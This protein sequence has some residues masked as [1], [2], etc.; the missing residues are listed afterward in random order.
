MQNEKARARKIHRVFLLIDLIF[1]VGLFYTQV[2]IIQKDYSSSTFEETK[3]FLVVLIE[4]LTA[5][6]EG[7]FSLLLVVSACYITSWVTKSTGKR[8]NTCLLI[9]HIINLILLIA[10]TISV[11]IF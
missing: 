7:V 3:D 9:W 4:S 5:F 6:E 10:I 8:Q 2:L 1:M 11:S